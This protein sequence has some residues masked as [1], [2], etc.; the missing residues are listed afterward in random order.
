LFLLSIFGPLFLEIIT[1]QR[2]YT[3]NETEQ[4]SATLNQNERRDDMQA[5][6][7]KSQ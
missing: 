4:N 1:I 6:E 3:L 5:L 2:E 7:A